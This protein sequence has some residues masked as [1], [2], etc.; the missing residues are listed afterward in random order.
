[1]QNHTE[2]ERLRAAEKDCQIETSQSD[3]PDEGVSSR[4]GDLMREMG[5][6]I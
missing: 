6:K 5:E 4:K 3:G 2:G 1:M